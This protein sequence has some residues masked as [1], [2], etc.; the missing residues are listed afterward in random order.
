MSEPKIEMLGK[1]PQEVLDA[2]PEIIRKITEARGMAPDTVFVGTEQEVEDQ[3]GMKT[4]GA[5]LT[6]LDEDTGEIKSLDEILSVDLGGEI[7]QGILEKFQDKIPYNGVEGDSCSCSACNLRRAMKGMDRKLDKER[8]VDDDDRAALRNKIELEN[9]IKAEV[10]AT[11]YEG[12]FDDFDLD[13]PQFDSLTL[14][15][16]SWLIQEK[17]RS[18]VK[19][20]R[21]RARN[22]QRCLAETVRNVRLM[23]MLEAVYPTGGPEKPPLTAMLVKSVLVARIEAGVKFLGYKED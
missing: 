2:I 17:H 5:M 16:Q 19:S 7:L 11:G 22:V 10:R 6:E 18:M 8:E 14:G 4:N 9:M 12:D 15:A 13:S 3:L 21:E 20:L 23:A 1:V